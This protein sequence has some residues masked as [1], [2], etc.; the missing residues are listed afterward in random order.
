M[1]A[2][3]DASVIDL[4][5]VITRSIVLVICAIFGGWS[6]VLGARMYQVA[7]SG[8]SHAELS[9]MGFKLV[10]KSAGPGL[11]LIGFGAVIL[12]LLI[13]RP[14]VFHDSAETDDPRTTPAPSLEKQSSPGVGKLDENSGAQLIRVQASASASRAKKCLVWVRRREFSTGQDP[15]SRTRIE[16]ALTAASNGLIRAGEG[17]IR[18]PIERAETLNTLEELRDATRE[19]E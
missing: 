12:S 10:L 1:N 3:G 7:V 15:L 5:M 6:I 4:V 16:A 19:S 8:R 9:G 18:S 14:L 2:C 17:G 11:C 13:M